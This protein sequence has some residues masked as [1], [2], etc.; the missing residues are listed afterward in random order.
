[1][2]DEELVAIDGEMDGKSDAEE[3]VCPLN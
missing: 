2:E 3:E 1:V